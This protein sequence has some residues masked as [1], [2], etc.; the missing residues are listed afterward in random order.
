MMLLSLSEDDITRSNCR[1]FRFWELASNVEVQIPSSSM[2][3][4][5]FWEFKKFELLW[6]NL[7]SFETSY[8]LSKKWGHLL[9]EK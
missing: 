8:S 7:H 5:L 3:F 4:L 9:M 6:C 1:A 2:P